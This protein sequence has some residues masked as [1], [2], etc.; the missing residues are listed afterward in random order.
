LQGSEPALL[1]SLGVVRAL[2]PRQTKQNGFS[3]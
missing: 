1:F 2:H 3:P